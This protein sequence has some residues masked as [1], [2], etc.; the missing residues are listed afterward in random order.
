MTLPDPVALAVPAF[1]VL[2]LAEVVIARLRSSASYELR[3]TAAS[4]LMGLGNF[5]QGLATAGL[6]YLATASVWQFRL[7][8]IGYTWWA[9]LAIFLAEDL[10]YYWFHRLSHEHRIWWAAHVNHHSSQH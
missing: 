4:L 1:I 3:D 5:A 9:F 2:V 10:C 7:F 8:D 6:L